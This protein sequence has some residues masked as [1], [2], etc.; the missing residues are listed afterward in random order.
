M[1]ERELLK[2]ALAV[3][4]SYAAVICLFAAIPAIKEVFAKPPEERN[5]CPRCGK[6]VGKNDWDIHTCT[7]PEKNT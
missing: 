2:L 7:P 6:R 5:F 1:T 4:E 3:L